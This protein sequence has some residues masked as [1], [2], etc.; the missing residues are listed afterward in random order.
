VILELR[1]SGL[2]TTKSSNLQN[3]RTVHHTAPRR[4]IWE[5]LWDHSELYKQFADNAA[6]KKWLSDTIFST[7][8]DPPSAA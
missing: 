2:D 5:F 3:A 6:F 8:Y 1:P 7:T 4:V